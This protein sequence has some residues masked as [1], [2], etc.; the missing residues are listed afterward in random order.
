MCKI[1][2]SKEENELYDILKSYF[3]DLKKQL[4]IGQYYYDMYLDNKIIEYN[5]DYWHG[6]PDIYEFDDFIRISGNSGYVAS[7][8]W[9]KDAKKKL[10]AEEYGYSVLIVWESEYKE[11]HNF[12]IEKCINFLKS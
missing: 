11:Y 12:I 2:E 9:A 8:L 4:N 6:N 10:L 5:G 3:P 1:R 7:D